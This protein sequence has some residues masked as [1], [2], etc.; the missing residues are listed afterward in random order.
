[1]SPSNVL[2][3]NVSRSRVRL[4]RAALGSLLLALPAWGCVGLEGDRILGRDLAAADAAFASLAP[5]IEIGLAPLAGAKRVMKSTELAAWADRQGIAR[6]ALP[7]VVCFE[8]IAHALTVEQLA[9]LL[10]ASLGTGERVVEILDY[11]RARIPQGRLEFPLHGLAPTGLWRGRVVYAAGKSVPVWV[12][13]RMPATQTVGA[14]VR[15]GEAVTVEVR[16]GAARLS[17]AAQAES[18]GRAGDSVMIRN[19]QT[20]RLFSAKVEATGKVV[21]QR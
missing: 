9:P 12:K 21:L 16:S 15:R 17:F 1:M 18:A 3:I 11:S 10:Q 6:E 7:A 19:P 2:R 20:G 13:I 8:R 5:T 14:A 4:N